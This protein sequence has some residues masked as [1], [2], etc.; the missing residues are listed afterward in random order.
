MKHLLTVTDKDITGSEKLSAAKPRIAVN[1]VLFDID[2]NP[3][4]VY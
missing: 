2:G 3:L 1:A 4:Y